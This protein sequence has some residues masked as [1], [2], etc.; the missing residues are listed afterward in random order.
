MSDL[1]KAA[2]QASKSPL[3]KRQP[4]TQTQ[5]EPKPSSPTH[6]R[7]TWGSRHV[8]KT[9]HLRTDLLDQAREQADKQG[10]SLS[11]FVNQTIEQAL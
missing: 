2:Q 7:K 1:L 6:D 10:I 8:R 3:V 11:A 4:S 5:P 9:L